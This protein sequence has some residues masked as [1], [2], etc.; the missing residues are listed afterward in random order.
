M[1]GEVFCWD[2]RKKLVK[3]ELAKLDKKALKKVCV[4]FDPSTSIWMKRD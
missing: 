3:T 4:F 1:N 2:F